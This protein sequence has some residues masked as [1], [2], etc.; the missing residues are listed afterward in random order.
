MTSSHNR[1]VH[2]KEPSAAY[3]SPL[4]NPEPKSEQL[5]RHSFDDHGWRLSRH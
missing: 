1:D 2:P 5:R 4:H 3:W